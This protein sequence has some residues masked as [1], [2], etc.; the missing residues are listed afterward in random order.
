MTERP[1]QAEAIKANIETLDAG[2]SPLTI[3][4][5]GTGKTVVI[6]KVLEWA[7]QHGM[8]SLVVAHRSLLLDQI[9]KTVMDW[10]DLV[11]DREQADQYANWDSPLILTTPA[12]LK[13][14]RLLRKPKN[15]DLIVIDEC[16][17]AVTDSMMSMYD[18]F[19]TAL[20][21]GKTATADR[22]D[23]VSLSTVFDKIAYQY[24]L[25]KGIKDGWL[26]KIVGRRVQDM[27]ID[28]SA[29]RI[30]AGD[31]SDKDLGELLEKNLVPIAHNLVKETK[32]RKKALIFLPTVDSS[33]HLSRILTEMGE[34]ADY[35]SGE[36]A[37]GNGEVFA[38]F[39]AGE[40]K[41][42]CSCQLVVEGYDEPSID[43][44]VMLR[45][46]LSRI[47]YSQAIGRGTRPY[48]G[49]DHCLLLEF[50]YNSN[51]HKL[52]TPYE[53]LGDNMSERIV[54]KASRSEESGD[55]DF[56]EILEKIQLSHYDIKEI[57]AR[58]VRTDFYFESFNPLDV[59]DMIGVDLDNEAAVWFEGRQLTGGVTER[60]ADILRRYMVDTQGLTKA[61]ASQLIGNLM[62]R[63]KPSIG[64][65]TPTQFTKL[66]RLYP[67]QVFPPSLT[68][69]AANLLITSYKESDNGIIQRAV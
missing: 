55:L 57:V 5:T 51:K 18:H 9:T 12:T 34:S 37:K 35:V 13:G 66:N 10:T 20:K 68:K 45:P 63:A 69:A 16:H 29:L 22:P 25:A 52:V 65:A 40:I 59:G 8:R 49:K 64:Y 39:K 38:R 46:T 1:Y 26:A 50:T 3:M 4:A 61:K 23:G 60:Q 6:A 41:Y 24:S 62:D 31:F 58:A 42:L 11:P 21:M 33:M 54:D 2:L 30:Q 67:G 48:M 15:R 19:N 53:L 28:L 36:R 7:R 47:V 17:R 32:D 56:L 27:E 43:T 44:I 14:E